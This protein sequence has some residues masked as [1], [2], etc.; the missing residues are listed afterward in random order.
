MTA[1]ISR[2]DGKVYWSGIGWDD[3]LTPDTYRIEDAVDFVFDEEDY[4]RVMLEARKWAGAPA[5]AEL[6]SS[7]ERGRLEEEW[8]PARSEN[9]WLLFYL[10][11][12]NVTQIAR[13]CGINDEAVR[14]SIR[15]REALDPTISARRLILHDRPRRGEP[16]KVGRDRDWDRWYAAA[17]RF[18]AQHGRFPRQ[19]GGPAEKGMQRWL[20]RQR[21][22]LGAGELDQRQVRLLDALGEWR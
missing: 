18:I 2:A 14:H 16:R 6:M 3:S 7:N 4:E 9:E 19:L 17:F 22:K 20:Y 15:Q 21:L 13:L 12:L 8:P 5:N 10:G 11:G 1:D